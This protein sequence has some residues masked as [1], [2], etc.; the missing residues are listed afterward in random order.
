MAGHVPSEIRDEVE[1]IDWSNEYVIAVWRGEWFEFYISEGER[2]ITNDFGYSDA[3]KNFIL[4]I[5]VG[6]LPLIAL[7]IYQIK[8]RGAA[9][10]PKK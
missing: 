10:N 4:T 8:I 5:G 9:P 7:M 3:I 6:L 1:D 2:Y